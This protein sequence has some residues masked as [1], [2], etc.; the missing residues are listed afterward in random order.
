MAKR[1]KGTAE[2]AKNWVMESTL[3]EEQKAALGQFISSF[4]TQTFFKKERRESDPAWLR[5]LGN[6]LLG[7]DS[8]NLLWYQFNHFDHSEYDDYRFQDS[9]YNDQCFAK[10]LGEYSEILVEGEP[11][12]IVAAIMEN[13]RS[14]LAVKSGDSGDLAVYDFSYEDVKRLDGGKGEIPASMVQQAFPSY[15]EM[16][17]RVSAVMFSEDEIV[18]ATE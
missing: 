3:V 18:E 11:L 9:F 6:I 2:E 13:L 4:P 10:D 7:V 1:I 12:L 8:E 15:A 5:E 14:V 16:L 17:G